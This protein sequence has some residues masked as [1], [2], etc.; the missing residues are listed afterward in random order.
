M[1]DRNF[2]QKNFD[3]FDKGIK[4]LA[5]VSH[6]VEQSLTHSNSVMAP[7]KH[8]LPTTETEATMALSRNVVEDRPTGNFEGWG[9]C[10]ID[11]SPFEVFYRTR[12]GL[13]FGWEAIQEADEY[14]SFEGRYTFYIAHPSGD[15]YEGSTLKKSL[16]EHGWRI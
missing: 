9:E 6:S 14:G 1:K 13:V 2:A 8:K 11:I 10:E 16:L 5:Q 15:F 12:G 4:E 3:S 7:Y